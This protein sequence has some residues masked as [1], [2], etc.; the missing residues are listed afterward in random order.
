MSLF[1]LYQEGIFVAKDTQPVEITGSNVPDAQPVPTKLI[2]SQS[3][4]ILGGVSSIAAS[5]T[6]DV[7]LDNIEWATD[8]AVWVNSNGSF[9]LFIW[10]L[11]DSAHDNQNTSTRLEL[12]AGNEFYGAG[13]WRRY[14]LANVLPAKYIRIQV[15]NTAAGAATMGLSHM[16]KA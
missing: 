12:T 9:Q 3:S 13:N 15:L 11:A 1:F 4:V 16:L 2:T 7:T 8:G 5:A 10:P 6:K 14:S